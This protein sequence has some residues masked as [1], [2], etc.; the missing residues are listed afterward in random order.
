MRFASEALVVFLA[1]LLGAGSVAGQGPTVEKPTPSPTPSPSASPSLSGKLLSYWY[2]TPAQRS[3][4]PLLHFEDAAEVRALE[5]NEAIA[6]FFDSGDEKG[7]MKR[8]ATPGGAPTLAEMAPYRPHT[9][10]S[11]DFLALAKGIKDA[12]IGVLKR[13]YTSR[14]ERNEQLLRE[15]LLKDAAS[16]SPTPGPSPGASP[17]PSPSPAPRPS[18]R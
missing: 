4:V 2:E 11:L 10:P 14:V 8:G 1:S 18:L 9:S 6:R 12:G 13:K 3:A 16:P 15:L 7:D 17:Q 5:M